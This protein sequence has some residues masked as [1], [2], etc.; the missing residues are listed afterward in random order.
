MITAEEI[1]QALEKHKASALEIISK[2]E[3][4]VRDNSNMIN[5][6]K[7]LRDI[8]EH[9]EKRPWVSNWEFLSYSFDSSN[10]LHS[11]IGKIEYLTTVD[12]STVSE[13]YVRFEIMQ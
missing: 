9:P 5:A 10:K 13:K 11:L 8:V 12:L 7:S 3:Q 6:L 4:K 2:A 1:Q